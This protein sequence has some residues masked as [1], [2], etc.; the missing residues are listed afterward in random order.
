ME[1]FKD[2]YLEFIALIL[3]FFIVRAL[4]LSLYKLVKVKRWLYPV[5]LFLSMT[6]STIPLTLTQVGVLSENLPNFIFV[7]FN[8][9]YMVYLMY[10]LGKLHNGDFR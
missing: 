1:F 4:I 2:E 8:L 6:F 7:V 10:K 3:A 9:I 5:P